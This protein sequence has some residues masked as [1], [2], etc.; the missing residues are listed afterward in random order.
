MGTDIYLSWKGMTKEEEESQITGYAT[1]A[2]D[3]GYLRASIGMVLENQSL[4]YIFPS[5]YWEGKKLTYNFKKN[6][7][8]VKIALRAYEKAIRSGACVLDLKLSQGN[9]QT[10][11]EQRRLGIAI[12]GM[13]S[14]FGDKAS[15]PSGAISEEDIGFGLVWAK[16]VED[17][18]NLGLEKQE[19][20][21]RPMV[22]ILW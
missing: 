14:P 1:D 21:L 22:R 17:F 4:R 18:F 13:L 7:N 20:G 11:N 16:S 9:E 19:Q 5:H 3:K 6:R 10:I 8:Q 15:M 2:G 12:L